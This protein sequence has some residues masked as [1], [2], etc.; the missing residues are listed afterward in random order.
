M[1]KS[2]LVCGFDWFTAHWMNT[3]GAAN[4]AAYGITPAD[5]PALATGCF[6]EC[7]SA[8][9]HFH[10]QKPFSACAYLHLIA[11]NACLCV[12]PWYSSKEAQEVKYS[13]LPRC[14]SAWSLASW[15]PMCVCHSFHILH[16]LQISAK[17]GLILTS[18]A[19]KSLVSSHFK[20]LC[21]WHVQLKN[22]MSPF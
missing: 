6:C 18:S 15:F 21:H 20:E 13:W 17:E 16:L 12:H 7:I 2:V 9:M 4:I 14:W 1:C 11:I 8:P 19:T 10:I 3:Y 22:H 5:R